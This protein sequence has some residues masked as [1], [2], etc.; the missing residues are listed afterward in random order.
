[1]E[2]PWND[3]GAL[4]QRYAPSIYRLA[5]AR[6]GCQADAED[7]MQEVFL[8]LIKARPFFSGEEQARAWLFRVAANCASDL[9]RLPW[10]R[11]E[12]PLDGLEERLPASDTPESGSVTE[13]VLSL[14]ARYRIPIHLYYYEDFSVAEI[15]RIIGRS[16]GTVKSRLFRARNL[17]RKRLT[18]EDSG[19]GQIQT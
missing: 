2:G 14:P 9:I 19:E 17:L 8:R 15:A 13:A 7:V 18:E 4:V 6:T 10:R 12:L 3:P 5:Y 11:R 1:M 16:E